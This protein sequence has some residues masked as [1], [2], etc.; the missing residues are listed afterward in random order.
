[1]SPNIFRREFPIRIHDVDAAGIVFFARYYVLMHD[2][3][4]SFLESIGFSISSVIQD[5]E[6]LIPVVE[7]HCRYRRPMRHGEVITG[8]IVLTELKSTS[9][10]V[11]CRL[12]GPDGDLRAVL[13]VRHVSVSQETMKP[14]PIPDAIRAALTFHVEPDETGA[15]SGI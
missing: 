6:I 14:V 11:R 10:I 5:G 1:M 9:Y 4:E 8:E 2:V 12:L 7:S 13:T 15:P 3:Y